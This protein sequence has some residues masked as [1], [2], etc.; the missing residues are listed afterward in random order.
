MQRVH[1]ILKTNLSDEEFSITELCNTLGMSRSQLYRK[2][3][4]LT[5]NSVHRFIQKMRL[6]KA[7]ELLLTTKLHVNEVAY[8]SGF[9][10]PSHFSRLYSQEFG[11]SPSKTRNQVIRS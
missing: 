6:V 8:D 11:I 9:K 7:K 3:S 10:N 2:F 1:Q 4:A 5:N